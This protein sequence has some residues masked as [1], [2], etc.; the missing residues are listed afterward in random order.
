[1]RSTFRWNGL[2]R[3]AECAVGFRHRADDA[4]DRFVDRRPAT[5]GS[6][7]HAR[8]ITPLT[9]ATSQKGEAVE[10]VISQLLLDGDHRLILPQGSR[11]TGTV[12]Q[13]Q[14]AHRLKKD[15]RLRIQFQGLIQ[16]DGI[17]EKVEAIPDACSRAKMPT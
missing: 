11:L 17:Q 9:S 4:A 8:L 3:G 15:E 16:P 10:A 13:V 6:V 12:R 2:F 7:V 14:P 5:P 1:M